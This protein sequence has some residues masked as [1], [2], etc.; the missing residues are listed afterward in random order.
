VLDEAENVWFMLHSGSR[1]V[2]NRM[3]AYFIR[4]GRKDMQSFS[5]TCR[6]GLAISRKAPSISTITSKPW[7]GRRILPLQ[8]DLM[9]EQVVGAVRNSGEVPVRREVKAINCHHNYVARE[10]HYGQ[11][12]LVTLGAVRAREATWGS[13]RKHGSAS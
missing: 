1:G 5:S 10:R 4:S 3:A 12:H 9:M 6:T 2:G 13:F 7:N 8:P 11:K